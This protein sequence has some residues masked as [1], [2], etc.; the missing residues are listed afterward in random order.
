[1]SVEYWNK[2]KGEWLPSHA[3]KPEEV[4]WLN[5]TV[6]WEMYREVE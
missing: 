2:E 5:E 1:M 6:G 3:T 4:D